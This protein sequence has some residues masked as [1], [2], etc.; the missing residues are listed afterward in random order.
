[1]R[2]LRLDGR[3][4]GRSHRPGKKA[5]PCQRDLGL[6]A[7]SAASRARQVPG[8]LQAMPPS[9]DDRRAVQ[10]DRHGT[11]SG[12]IYRRCR[13]DACRAYMAAYWQ[14]YKS[15]SWRYSTEQRLAKSTAARRANQ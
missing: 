14:D 11:A 6:R 5:M 12:Y 3:P 2:Q 13:C 10:T 1:M 7:A 4:P 9:Q 8:A 15:R